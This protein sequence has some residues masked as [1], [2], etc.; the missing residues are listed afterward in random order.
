MRCSFAFFTGLNVDDEHSR[1]HFNPLVHMF[2][3]GLSSYQTVFN[4]C[5][6]LMR[7]AWRRGIAVGCRI[8]DVSAV[9]PARSPAANCQKYKNEALGLGVLHFSNRDRDVSYRT[10]SRKALVLPPR[11]QRRPAI[12]AL[13]HPP[14]V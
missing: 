9:L 12:F 11:L 6:P 4:I 13:N 8:G 7:G 10:V 14:T 3:R 5:V 1:G 2:A